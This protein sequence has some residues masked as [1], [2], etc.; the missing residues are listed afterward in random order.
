MQV[1]PELVFPATC[2]LS[3]QLPVFKLHSLIIHVFSPIPESP[4]ELFLFPCFDMICSLFELP[5][6]HN[7]NMALI[8]WCTSKEIN[9]V[10]HIVCIEQVWMSLHRE[11]LT[12]GG[13]EPPNTL[14]STLSPPQTPEKSSWK[15]IQPQKLGNIKPQVQRCAHNHKLLNIWRKQTPRKRGS[16][17]NK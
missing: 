14:L 10:Q 8:F 12:A 3:I 13:M 4:R 9:P 2:A 1:F 11:L 15:Q 7:F 16:K 17:D 5:E 6:N